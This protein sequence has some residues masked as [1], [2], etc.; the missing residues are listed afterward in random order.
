MSQKPSRSKGSIY[1]TLFVKQVIR[2]AKSD[3]PAYQGKLNVLDA[4]QQRRGGSSAG[5]MF[6]E[7]AATVLRKVRK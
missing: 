6:S 7:H 3:A 4:S 2:T 5:A 1:D